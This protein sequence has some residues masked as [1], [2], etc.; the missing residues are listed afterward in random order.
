MPFFSV[1]LCLVL[2]LF[3]FLIVHD[4][5]AV[6]KALEDSVVS[7]PL[8]RILESEL[9]SERETVLAS[10]S[11]ITFGFSGWNYTDLVELY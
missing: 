6:W 11:W 5:D 10:C 3:L 8:S 1:V 9:M 2:F 4:V 7:K